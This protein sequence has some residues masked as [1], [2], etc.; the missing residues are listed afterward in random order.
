MPQK[1][2]PARLRTLGDNMSESMGEYISESLGDF[3]GI[4][5][6]GRPL[7]M[8][9]EIMRLPPGKELVLVHGKAPILADRISYFG[10][11]EFTDLFDQNPMV[12][13]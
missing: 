2:Q 6:T 5:T 4:S 10:D 1:I 7:L 9:Q 12:S 3:V 11:R 13:S 8:P